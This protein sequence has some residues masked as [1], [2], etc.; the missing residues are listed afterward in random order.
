QNK[1]KGEDVPE[2]IKENINWT[3]LEVVFKEKRA[4]LAAAYIIGSDDVGKLLCGVLKQYIRFL[5]RPKDKKDARKRR[6]EN[7]AW[8]D[9]LLGEVE[10]IKLTIKPAD[11]SIEDMNTWVEKQISPTIA[12]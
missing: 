1:K 8:W 2:P 5:R 3:R 12:A 4:E 6:W 9:K 7:A 11:K 10:K